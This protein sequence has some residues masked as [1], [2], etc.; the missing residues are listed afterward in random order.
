LGRGLTCGGATKG[1]CGAGAVV[2]PGGGAAAVKDE[3]RLKVFRS[4]DLEL[5]FVAVFVDVG[6]ILAIFGLVVIACGGILFDIC[7]GHID[8]FKCQCDFAFFGKTGSG[9]DPLG[10]AGTNN[11]IVRAFTAIIFVSISS[12]VIAAEIGDI[13]ALITVV[14][15][16]GTVIAGAVICDTGVP[17]LDVDAIWEGLGFYFNRTVPPD[18]V[19]AGSGF[20]GSDGKSHPKESGQADEKSQSKP[21]IE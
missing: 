21:P 3:A 20:I 15:N 13:D 12:F 9:A 4:V 2:F 5:C 16:D 11:H 14:F 10:L 6:L 7:L 18:F 17:G 1:I 8:G 19:R